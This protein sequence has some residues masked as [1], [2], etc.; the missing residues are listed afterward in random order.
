MFS[1]PARE[2]TIGKPTD[3]FCFFVDR[4]HD[5]YE[6]LLIVTFLRFLI[7]Y[8]LTYLFV[9]GYDFISL[10]MKENLTRGVDQVSILWH[11]HFSST[12]H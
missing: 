5:E 1:I 10:T 6:S 3:F 7:H 12:F 11:I 2:S 4:Y 9:F 8:I